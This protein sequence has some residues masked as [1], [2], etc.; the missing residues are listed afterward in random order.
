MSV[1][2]V[3]PPAADSAIASATVAP[4]G[5]TGPRPLPGSRRGAFA[6][7]VPGAVLAVGLAGCGSSTGEL[8]IGPDA[9]FA[10]PVSTSVEKEIASAGTSGADVSGRAPLP[11]P[12]PAAAFADP[13]SS[14]PFETPDPTAGSLVGRL[15]RPALAELADTVAAARFVD[16]YLAV[17]EALFALVASDGVEVAP[18]REL[19]DCPDG[20]RVRVGRDGGTRDGVLAFAFENCSLDGVT[21]SGDL[22]RST[23]PDGFRVG[24]SE[25]LGLD[26]RELV[27]DGGGARATT[28][29]GTTRRDVTRRA[30]AD[31][32]GED[33]ELTL[34]HRIGT[35]SVMRDGLT[36]QVTDVRHDLA[37]TRLRESANGEPAGCHE[38]ST[39][40]FDGRASVTGGPLDGARADVRRSGSIERDTRSDREPPARATLL[41][42]VDDGSSL[43][44]RLLSDPDG[45]AQ[46]DVNADA[47]AVSYTVDFRF[48]P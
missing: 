15:G 44:L 35:A 26:Y 28:L 31:C 17:D 47:A 38:R 27:V 48:E 9:A 24:S 46:V 6:S 11:S 5:A 41:A 10:D 4:L 12:E 3:Q 13:A 37:L 22:V 16:D 29:T 8:P 7:V 36:V 40:E 34:S 39:A 45:T 30:N 1:D 33:V 23:T 25:V 14:S 18:G 43:A 20:G 32:G 21:L 19:L 42:E 2:P